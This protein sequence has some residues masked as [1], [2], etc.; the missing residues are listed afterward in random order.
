MEKETD[1]DVERLV[2]LAELTPS[3]FP[4][5][6][7]GD[8]AQRA[9]ARAE[10][11]QLIGKPEAF[12]DFYA[13]LESPDSSLPY[14]PIKSAPEDWAH[15]RWLQV[16]MLFATDLFVRYQGRLSNSLTPAVVTRLEHDV[17]DAQILALGILEGALATK[18]LKLRR[19]WQTLKPTGT[20]MPKDA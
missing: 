4:E 8:D 20:L 3:F 11:E 12:L 2:S 10:V 6:L 14:P 16:L 9:S 13:Q 7:D 1:A 18:E 15:I 17:H 19:W 5:L